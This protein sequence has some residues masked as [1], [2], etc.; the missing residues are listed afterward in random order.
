MLNELWLN[1]KKK[2]IALGLNFTYEFEVDC[3]NINF[4][5]TLRIWIYTENLGH[6]TEEVNLLGVGQIAR[7]LVATKFLPPQILAGNF[8]RES[9]TDQ[10]IL[11]VNQS[12]IYG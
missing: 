5:I 10:P 3:I 12:L 7:E 9:G 11:G 6:G 4:Q 8:K 2:N 1:L